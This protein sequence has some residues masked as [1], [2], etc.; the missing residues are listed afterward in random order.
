MSS[1]RRLAVLAGAGVTSAA[2][3]GV[4]VVLA[5]GTLETAD[6]YASVGSLFVG[7]VGLALTAFGLISARRP[8]PEPVR[9]GSGDHPD[10]V[11]INDSSGIVLGPHAPVYIDVDSS[12]RR[13]S[14][15]R[16]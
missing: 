5:S 9:P 2:L 15:R 8:D 4:G 14:R 7:I 12:A 1:G 13:R 6:R 11:E 16:G 10:G 3:V